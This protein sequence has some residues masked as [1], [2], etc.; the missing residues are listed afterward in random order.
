ML[1]A[2]LFLLVASAAQPETRVTYNPAGACPRS[3]SNEDRIIRPMIVSGPGQGH[4][5][6]IHNG[7]RAHAFIKIIS[8]KTRPQL[9]FVGK[10]GTASSFPM[11]DG[12]YRIQYAIGGRL[13]KDCETVIAPESVGEFPPQQ[14]VTQEDADSIEFSVISFTLYTVRRGNVRSKKIT[15]AEFN[16][17]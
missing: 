7:S 2:N 12:T 15:V 1:T 8:L 17:N 6:V 4:E 16:K 14:F 11:S 9:F 10:G 3:L 13:A 5:V